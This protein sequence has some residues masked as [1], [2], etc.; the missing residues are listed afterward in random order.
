MWLLWLTTCAEARGEEEEGKGEGEAETEAEAEAEGRGSQPVLE[1]NW[2][3]IVCRVPL[4]FALLCLCVCVA[5]CSF[6]TTTP[7]E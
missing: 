4:L 1:E 5:N 2:W 7:K 6:A 3:K